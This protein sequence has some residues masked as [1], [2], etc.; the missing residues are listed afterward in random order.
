M[1]NLWLT[2]F[3]FFSL[4]WA[5]D[6]ILKKN[7]KTATIVQT[8]PIEI[9]SKDNDVLKGYFLQIEKNSIVLEGSY[10]E[11][12]LTIPFNQ[13]KEIKL[14]PSR[15][16]S[17]FKGCIQGG[18][19]LGGISAGIVGVMLSQ[20]TDTRVIFDDDFDLILIAATFSYA[21]VIGGTLNAIRHSI[22]AVE[23][24]YKID[25]DNWKIVAG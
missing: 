5:Q 15:L 8:Q 20:D 16:I 4:A 11:S 23:V 2:L 6:L 24:L 21:A 10:N 7:N 9:I 22:K 14:P 13:V 19:I 3:L 25:Q 12:L 18:L 1:K 17:A